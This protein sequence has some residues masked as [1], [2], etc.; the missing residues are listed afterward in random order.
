MSYFVAVGPM[1]A[2]KFHFGKKELCTIDPSQ[3][4]SVREV[5]VK[6]KF[7]RL[8]I[9]G[10]MHYKQSFYAS[11]NDRYQTE[12]YISEACFDDV[13]KL[14]LMIQVDPKQRY[15]VLKDAR[16][17]DNC[18]N[19]PHGH[20][21]KEGAV[22]GQ[23]SEFSTRYGDIFFKVLEGDVIADNP[24]EQALLGSLVLSSFTMIHSPGP[25]S[26]GFYDPRYLAV[27]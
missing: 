13:E 8:E 27:I 1:E 17:R 21:I 24:K 25:E 5:F 18:W 16:A 4:R 23:L 15:K 9:D 12:F 20:M 6:S 22:I 14:Q 3:F 26:R 10:V 19:S 2:V 7:N 11:K